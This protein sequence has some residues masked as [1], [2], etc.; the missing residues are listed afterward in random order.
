[1]HALRIAEKRTAVRG[2]KQNAISAP[3]GHCFQMSTSGDEGLGLAV[4]PQPSTN[5]SRDQVRRVL[6]KRYCRRSLK[7]GHSMQQVLARQARRLEADEV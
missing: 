6:R 5:A 7:A 3:W 1:M 2:V 4:D